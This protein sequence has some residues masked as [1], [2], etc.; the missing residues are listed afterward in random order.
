TFVVVAGAKVP[1]LFTFTSLFF[2]FFPCFKRFFLNTLI[3]AYLQ[4]YFF[5]Y[6][7]GF[8]FITVPLLYF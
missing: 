4:N 8:F 7:V 1:P 2:I 5:L 6:N 3:T